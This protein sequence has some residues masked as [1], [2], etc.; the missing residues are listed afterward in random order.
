[1]PI[2]ARQ[3]DAGAPEVLAHFDEMP[4]PVCMPD[5]T[6]VAYFMHGGGPGLPPVPES[7]QVFSRRSPDSGRT[8]TQPQPELTLPADAGGFGYFVPMTD[9]DGEVHLF[10]LND[11]N[12]GLIRP[13]HDAD[14]RRQVASLAHQRLDIWHVRSSRDATKWGTPRCIWQGRVGDPM[15]ATQLDNGRVVLPFCWVTD[16][17]WANR[18]AGPGAFTYRGTFDTGILTSDD[19]GETWTQAGSALSVPTPTLSTY[20]AI[21]P[22]AFPLRDGRVWLLVRTQMG[23][24]YESF[25]DDGVTWP[26]L[27]PSRFLSSDSPGLPIRLHDGRIVL[28]WNNCQR[29]AYG[30]GGRHVLHAAVS[31]DEG[32]T[33]RGYR[34][35]LR[36]PHRNEPPPPRGDFGQS[37]PFATVAPDNTIVFSLWVSTGEGRS[38]YRLDSDWLLQTKRRDDFSDGLS[39]WSVF[40]TRGVDL[41]C[42]AGRTGESVMALRRTD[43]AWPA[44]AVWNFPIGQRGTLTMSVQA[45][46][47]CGEITVGLTDHLSAPFDDQ[48]AF[49]NVFTVRLGAAGQHDGSVPLASGRWHGIDLEWCC[50]RRRCTVSVDGEQREILQQSRDSVGVCYLRLSASGKDGKARGLLLDEVSVSVSPA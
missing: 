50:T 3:S 26:E 46:P 8:W 23:R 20:G 15:G 17:T 2:E 10:F 5:G 28:I 14:G 41:V 22:V 27:E 45:E 33:W 34:E 39:G 21:E 47:G 7:Q 1:M 48:D 30:F 35:I 44:A 38:L 42:A 24:L 36:D 40:G 11:A 19:A 29:F 31:D 37:Y 43:P 25:S 9:R 49:H 18:G 4:K 32:A 13:R 12:E 16:R 6:L